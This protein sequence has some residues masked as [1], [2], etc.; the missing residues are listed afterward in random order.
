[1]RQGSRCLRMGHLG[2]LSQRA[3]GAQASREAHLV[4][5]E[6]GVRTQR[7]AGA[8]KESLW[9]GPAPTPQDTRRMYGVRSTYPSYSVTKVVK[10]R[11]LRTPYSVEGQRHTLLCKDGDS[12]P[13][14]LVRQ[15][16]ASTIPTPFSPTTNPTPCGLPRNR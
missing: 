15:A 8:R 10:G 2:G 4:P 14:T 16:T 12:I 13:T 3:P 9:L 7:Q 6:Y 11:V 5:A 1:M